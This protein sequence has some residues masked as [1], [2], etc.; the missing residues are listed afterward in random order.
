[1]EKM[2]IWIDLDSL[3]VAFEEKLTFN[4]CNQTFVKF[5]LC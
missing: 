5:L 3:A 2:E 1:M 4:W